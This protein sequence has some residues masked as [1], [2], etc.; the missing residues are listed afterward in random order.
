MILAA[1]ILPQYT[2]VTV[3]QTDDD[4]NRQHLMIISKRCICKCYC[5]TE[6]RKLTINT[7]YDHQSA[8]ESCPLRL[9]TSGA[10]YSTVPQ[11]ENVLF[12]INMDSL[13]S[14][15]SV[16]L[17]CPSVSSKILPHYTVPTTSQ[18]CMQNTTSTMSH[19][20]AYTVKRN[21]ALEISHIPSSP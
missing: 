1:A 11:N 9:T 19:S 20:H 8:D 14:P 7:P 18:S 17:M 5:E 10:M 2:H 16:S 21:T 3:V 15:K 13:L 6:T 4:D 12:S